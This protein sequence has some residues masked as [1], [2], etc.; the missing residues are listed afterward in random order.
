MLE[1]VAG[2]DASLDLSP[3]RFLL[4]DFIIFMIPTC[5]LRAHLD[6][7][8]MVSVVLEFELTKELRILRL[9]DISFQQNSSLI[10]C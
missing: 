9:H 8:P 3:K 2:F 5:E 7:A 6:F 10:A 1:I 4:L